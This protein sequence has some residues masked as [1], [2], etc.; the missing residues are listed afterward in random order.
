MS[1]FFVYI[2]VC[3]L[4]LKCGRQTIELLGKH[5]P[6]VVR[7]GTEECYISP[8]NRFKHSPLSVCGSSG[9]CS[10]QNRRVWFQMKPGFIWVYVSTCA[11]HILHSS[12][13]IHTYDVKPSNGSPGAR[14]RKRR[15]RSREMYEV[16]VLHWLIHIFYWH[17]ANTIQKKRQDTKEQDPF[18]ASWMLF[19]QSWKG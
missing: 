4:H 2:V 9:L 7:K 12:I 16:S 14:R 15:R 10:T 11:A 17:W 18:T 1:V 19:P 5:C 8:H 13:W 6:L 3:N